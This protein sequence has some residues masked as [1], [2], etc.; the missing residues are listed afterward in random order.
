MAR[1]YNWK[2]RPWLIKI[3]DLVLRKAKVS[4]PTHF[5]GELASNWE[6]PYRVVSMV[7]DGTYLLL[8]KKELNSPKC[9]TYP[10]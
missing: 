8:L 2:V 1:L 7:R 6:G 9:G 10:T 4:D 3:E 5:R